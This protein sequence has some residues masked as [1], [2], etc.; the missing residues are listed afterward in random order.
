MLQY[1]LQIITLIAILI[2]LHKIQTI[3]LQFPCIECIER[4]K[5]RNVFKR[6]WHKFH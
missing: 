4:R 5:L 3:Q 2:C 6:L 1:T